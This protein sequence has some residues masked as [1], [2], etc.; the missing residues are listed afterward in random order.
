MRFAIFSKTATDCNFLVAI[1]WLYLPIH[2]WVSL[3]VM[4]LLFSDL[5]RV[6]GLV[7]PILLVRKFQ[8]MDA[9]LSGFMNFLKIKF[10]CS[11]NCIFKRRVNIFFLSIN[12]HFGSLAFAWSQ[13]IPTNQIRC[14]FDEWIAAAVWPLRH[15][16]SCG[17]TTWRLG[18]SLHFD[19]AA[20]A[21]A[22]AVV[23]KLKGR[24]SWG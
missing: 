12:W 2:P 20:A 3:S 9:N 15:L 24:I 22:V 14:E 8:S 16:C 21:S 1:K 6:Y 13:S 17:M 19:T 4:L 7:I 10:N 18:S 11:S 5:C 23:G